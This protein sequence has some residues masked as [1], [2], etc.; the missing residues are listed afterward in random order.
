MITRMTHLSPV[1]FSVGVYRLFLAAYPKAFRDEYGPHMVQVFQDLSIRAYR[2]NGSDGILR[3][4]VITLFDL[5]KSVVEEH[6]QKETNMN[7]STFIRISGWSLILGAVAFAFLFL[8]WYLDENYPLLHWEKT[9]GEIMY[10][11]GFMIAPFL[12]AIGVLGLRSRYGN[13]IGKG[14][15]STL[16]VATI[17]GLGLTIL[18]IVGEYLDLF[19]RFSDTPFII[20]M[21]GNAVLMLSLALFGF[22]AMSSK[23]LPRWNGLPIVAGIIFPIMLFIGFVL[24]FLSEFTLVVGIGILIQL[25]S[26]V[27]LGFILQRDV[28]QEQVSMAAA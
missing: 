2:Q 4:W 21:Y 18:G 19:G 28:P 17:A 26:M 22:M 14:G 15:S 13:A 9:Y 3:L 10:I 20:L 5:F 16:L 12:T 8:G 11:S 7:K 1:R 6:L 24:N 27:I 23:P 25:I